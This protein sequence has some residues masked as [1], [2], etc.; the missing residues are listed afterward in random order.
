MYQLVAF[1]TYR[2]LFDVYSMDQLADLL[3]LGKGQALALMWLDRQI[4]YTRLVSMSA[5][6][7]MGRHLAHP[8]K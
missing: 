4:E 5:P 6:D 8:F 7:P 2:T 3:F 1:D